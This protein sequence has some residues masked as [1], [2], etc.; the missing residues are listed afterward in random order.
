MCSNLGVVDLNG[1]SDRIN[2]LTLSNNPPRRVTKKYGIYFIEE[3]KYTK[4]R[5]LY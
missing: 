2:A 5:I 3:Q 4:R 1:S